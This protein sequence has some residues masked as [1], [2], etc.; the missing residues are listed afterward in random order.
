MLGLDQIEPDVLPLDG[1][2]LQALR[3][4]RQPLRVP[5]PH[6]AAPV[7]LEP[8]GREVADRLEHREAGVAPPQQVVV[9]ERGQGLQRHLAYLLCGLEGA[10]A[11]EDAEARE[12]DA[13][14]R[15]EQV[16]APADRRRES[17]LARRR[18]ARTGGEEV[19][20][21]F[22]AR[23]DLG[24]REQLR[25][26]GRELD[27][28]RQSVEPAADLRDFRCAGRVELETGIDRLRPRR[29][30][31][32]RV[33][34]NERLE[35]KVGVRGVEG[36]H[37]ILA[38]RR[39]PQRRAARGQD[40]QARGRG[41]QIADEGRSREDL[42]EVVQDE[43]HSLL[44]QVLDH[45]FG[46]VPLTLAHTERLGDR[47]HQELRV[48]DRREADEQAPSRSSGSSSCAT[49]SPS[50]V[51][52]VPPAPVRVTSRAPSS[53]NSAPTAASSSRRPTSWVAGTGSGRVE[54]VGASGAARLGSW[55]RIA[56]SSSCERRARVE[57]ELLRQNLAGVAVD[58]EGV[59]LA[60]A[61]VERQQALL[62]EPLAV[63][64]LGGQRFELGDDG[65]V[66]AAGELRV[67][68]KLERRQA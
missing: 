51:L 48:R 7:L 33:G 15:A 26:R 8:L 38:L 11:S 41:E 57:A 31:P 42:L 3:Q 4:L 37:R 17:A 25:A 24:R 49:A 50:L 45:A 9:H 60:A 13:L 56:R 58:L 62:E 63:R 55:R 32:Q 52:P 61:P 1:S 2:L 66:P 64:M 30:Q 23:E 20:F 47:G 5:P 28:E 40:P 59:G 65:V 53:R 22:E 43:E 18:V 46:Q 67:V 6:L 19:R 36:R 16:V 35:R 39:E 12:R 34:L 21:P 68:A 10:A 44:A 27:R 14:V 54:R 29:E